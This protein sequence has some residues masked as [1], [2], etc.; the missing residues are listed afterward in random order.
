MN[1]RLLVLGLLAR[2]PMHGYELRK[3]TQLSRVE[4]WSGVLPG[5]IYHALGRLDQ[6][7][8]VR[9][10]ATEH[11]G[12]RERDVYEITDA[13]RAALVELVRSAWSAPVR[14]FP[15]SLYGAILFR[16][17][18][19]VAEERAGLDAAILGLTGEIEQWEAALPQ[20]AFSADQRAL[21]ENALAHL[22]LDLELVKQLRGRRRAPKTQA[23]GRTD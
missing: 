17:A 23:Q 7:G 6:E 20:K 8:L 18:L 2:Q 11:T 15:T 12:K 4:V 1:V 3:L 10:K 16:G 21:F 14:G 13:G 19:G 9:K 22:K 5:S